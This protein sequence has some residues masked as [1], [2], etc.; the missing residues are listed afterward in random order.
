[1]RRNLFSHLSSYA[2]DELER[3]REENG[4][5]FE[6]GED[7][8]KLEILVVIVLDGKKIDM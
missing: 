5:K 3:K 7:G 8:V 1:M 4:V 2:N 6:D